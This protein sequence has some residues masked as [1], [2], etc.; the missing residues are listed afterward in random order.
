MTYE[1]QDDD[2]EM[3]ETVLGD[4]LYEHTLEEIS[5]ALGLVQHVMKH[6][7]HSFHGAV[8]ERWLNVHFLHDMLTGAE[9]LFRSHDDDDEPEAEPGATIQ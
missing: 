2:E 6:V 1:A 8:P 7:D 9:V 4:A 3:A 5:A